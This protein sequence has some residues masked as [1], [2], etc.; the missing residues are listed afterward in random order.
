MI[1][2][3]EFE[4]D[5]KQRGFRFGTFAIKVISGLTGISDVHEIF[6]RIQNQ[7]L[8]VL[9]KF[10]YGC[11]VHFAEHKKQEVNFNEADVSDWCDELGLDK[12]NEMTLK[13]IKTYNEKN[14]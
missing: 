9:L 5:G 8:D 2:H 3:V 14:Q 13:L 6:R 10:Y 7:D 1:G 11:A 12:V 4:I